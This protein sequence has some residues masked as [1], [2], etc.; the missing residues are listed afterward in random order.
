MTTYAELKSRS[1]ESLDFWYDSAK[2]DFMI[3][4]HQVMTKEKISKSSL[5]AQIGASP[6]YISKILK[7][8]ANFTIETMVKISRALKTK[9][10][11]HLSDPHDSIRWMGVVS[12][13]AQPELTQQK[14]QQ[15]YWAVP[16]SPDVTITQR[17]AA[18]G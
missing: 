8:D 2:Q 16:H 3:S 9:L 7:G 1:K 5:A 6:A 17:I 4:V 12:R 11:I 13:A 14:S 18:H 15:K 10:C